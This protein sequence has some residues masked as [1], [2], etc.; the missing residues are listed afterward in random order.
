MDDLDEMERLLEEAQVH[1]ER[2]PSPR[3]CRI[4]ATSPSTTIATR[5]ASDLDARS[6]SSR[7]SKKQIDYCLGCKM[8]RGAM[9]IL[10]ITIEQVWGP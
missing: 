2:E 7:K 1:E 3:G 4:L 8:I 9:S 10:D 6:S 5:V